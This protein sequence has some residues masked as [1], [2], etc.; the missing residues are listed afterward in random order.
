MQ[1]TR[2]NNVQNNQ[3]STKQSFKSLHLEPKGAYELAGYFTENPGL[4]DVFM[5]QIAK[6]LEKLS[7]KVR[8][9]TNSVNFITPLQ[10]DA[11]SVIYGY[12]KD[13]FPY[14]MVMGL[15]GYNSHVKNPYY[16]EALKNP[17]DNFR[18]TNCPF[19]DLEVAK[20]IAED[21]E[22]RL[23]GYNCNNKVEISREGDVNLG[24]TQ[25]KQPGEV[26]IR[27]NWKFL[28]FEKYTKKAEELMKR[29][30]DVE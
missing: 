18:N 20:N 27:D 11:Y 3:M 24:Y 7:T 9:S 2:V 16:L 26:V 17:T 14:A 8:Y 29:F 22:L 5:K 6:P 1:V 30:P 10:K 19:K 4:E 12:G 23:Q 13:A 28:S 25:F 15:T 21:A